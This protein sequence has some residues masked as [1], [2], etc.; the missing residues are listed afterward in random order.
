MIPML[1]KSKAAADSLRAKKMAEPAWTPPFLLEQ[2]SA[3]QG[4]LH[5]NCIEASYS[6]SRSRA[7]RKPAR[8]LDGL[9]AGTRFRLTRY[10][11]TNQHT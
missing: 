9:L 7:W 6:W 1:E 11:A 3:D 4:H 2:L 10:L 5:S 8:I